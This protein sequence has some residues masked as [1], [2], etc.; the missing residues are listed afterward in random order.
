MQQK[1]NSRNGHIGVVQ[2]EGMGELGADAKHA[3]RSDRTLVFW[4]AVHQCCQVETAKVP[5]DV[6]KIVDSASNGVLG[7]QDCD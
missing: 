5:N 2:S 3:R 1:L 6:E 4:R 7:A